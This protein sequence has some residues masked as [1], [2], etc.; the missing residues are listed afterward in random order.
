[1][2]TPGYGTHRACSALAYFVIYV[3]RR[4]LLWHIAHFFYMAKHASDVS[5]YLFK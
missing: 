3:A 1:M 5:Q 2:S 4:E